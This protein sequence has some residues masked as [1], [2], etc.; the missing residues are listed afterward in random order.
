MRAMPM[1]KEVPRK[2]QTLATA[3]DYRYTS[4]DIEKMLE[5]KKKV[6]ELTFSIC[7][8]LMTHKCSLEHF[9]SR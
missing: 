1:S 4:E 9:L 3:E 7:F 5:E 8:N 2:L 6:H